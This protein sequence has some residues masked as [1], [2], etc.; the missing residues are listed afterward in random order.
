MPLEIDKVTILKIEGWVVKGV[1]RKPEFHHTNTNK[2]YQFHPD[3]ELMKNRMP[4]QMTSKQLEK[5]IKE[6]E[7]I[8]SLVDAYNVADELETAE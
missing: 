7:E 2:S 4:S 1:I 5:Y 6:L 8:K 3:K